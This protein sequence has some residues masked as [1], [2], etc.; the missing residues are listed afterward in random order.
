LHQWLHQL[1]EIAHTEG[2]LEWLAE[3]LSESLDEE[4]RRRLVY[5][6]WG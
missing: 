1:A 3:S 5:L 6:L 4:R 2:G